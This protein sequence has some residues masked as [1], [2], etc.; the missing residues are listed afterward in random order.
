MK[1]GAPADEQDGHQP[2]HQDDHLIDL[3]RVSRCLDR[4]PQQFLH[5]RSPSGSEPLRA[6]RF[7]AQCLARALHEVKD[8]PNEAR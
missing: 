7:V 6:L 3:A 8:E 2:V 1:K 4:Q 5:L